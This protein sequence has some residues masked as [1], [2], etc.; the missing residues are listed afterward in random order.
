MEK[1]IDT[2]YAI[3][4]RINQLIHKIIH[5]PVKGYKR[6]LTIKEILKGG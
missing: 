4:W 1:I 2:K 5:K 6:T 3:C